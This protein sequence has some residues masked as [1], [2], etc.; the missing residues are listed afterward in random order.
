MTTVLFRN[1]EAPADAVVLSDSEFIQAALERISIE[2]DYLRTEGISDASEVLDSFAVMLE[3]MQEVVM[4]NKMS[5]LVA[6]EHIS[7][8]RQEKGSFSDKKAVTKE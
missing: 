8:V 5:P 3:L 1:E 4:K 2:A 7:T 6:M